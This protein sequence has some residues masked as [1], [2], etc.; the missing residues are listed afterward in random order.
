MFVPLRQK[1]VRFVGFPLKMIIV[2]CGSWFTIIFFVGPTIG[3]AMWK[4]QYEPTPPSFT[5]TS[6]HKHCHFLNET[7]KNNHYLL[8]MKEPE[9]TVEYREEKNI[10][11][12]F[13]Y[14]F[15]SGARLLSCWCSVFVVYLSNIQ[16]FR[17]CCW[18]WYSFCLVECSMPMSI[19]FA[20]F[21]FHLQNFQISPI[22]PD[23]VEYIEVTEFSFHFLIS[24]FHISIWL[25]FVFVPPLA[26]IRVV[27]VFICTLYVARIRGPNFGG[28]V[29]LKISIFTICLRIECRGNGKTIRICKCIYLFFACMKAYG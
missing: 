7:N 29:H 19:H 23:D 5:T 28:N 12:F 10:F 2:R 11:F 3:P 13:N 20:L 4:N 25:S 27:S 14:H 21:S 1:C 6:K 18:F 17:R 26:P 15:T 22:H 24:N 16:F 9:Y 8:M